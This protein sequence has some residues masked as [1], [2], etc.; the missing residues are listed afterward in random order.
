M[1]NILNTRKNEIVNNIGGEEVLKKLQKVK[2]LKLMELEIQQLLEYWSLSQTLEIINSEL[3][4]KIS[5]TLF[6]DFYAKNLKKNETSK[7]IKRENQKQ[8]EVDKDVSQVNQPKTKG[9]SEKGQLMIAQ[10]TELKDDGQLKV[11]DKSEFI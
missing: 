7:S 3:G 6:Y 8:I 11:A 2:L 1:K 5:K 4:F 10:T 9:N